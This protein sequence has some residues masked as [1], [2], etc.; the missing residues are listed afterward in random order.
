MKRETTV[1]FFIR[2]TRSYSNRSQQALPGNMETSLGS[3][4]A[5]YRFVNLLE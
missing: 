4:C 2:R 1:V 5:T 3:R